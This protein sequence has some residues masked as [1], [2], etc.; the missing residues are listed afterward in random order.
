[1]SDSVRTYPWRQLLG[2][3][4]FSRSGGDAEDFLFSPKKISTDVSVAD[5]EVERASTTYKQPWKCIGSIGERELSCLVYSKD[6]NRKKEY[7]RGEKKNLRQRMERGLPNRG[8]TSCS[9]LGRFS[10][11]RGI[12]TLLRLLIPRASN[13]VSWTSRSYPIT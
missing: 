4:T 9:N 10:G 2:N 6:W 13:A 1:M 3:A 12:V 5:I 8:R 11:L 7:R